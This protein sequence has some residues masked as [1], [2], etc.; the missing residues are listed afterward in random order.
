MYKTTVPI[1]VKTLA[2]YGAEEYLKNLEEMKADRVLLAIESYDVYEKDRSEVLGILK[3]YIPVFRN[4]GFEVG[5]W[6]WAFMFNG[7]KKYTHITSP[8]GA[9]SRGE[10]CPSDEDFRKFAAKCV[11]EI[12]AC[13]PDLILYDDDFR[14]GFLDCGLG[15]ACK[16]HRKYMSEILGEDVSEVELGKKVFGG[17]KN[18]YRSAFLRA[19][20]HFFKV[21]SK[22]MRAA[23][24]SV[25]PSIRIGVCACM[26]VWD[27]C[28]ISPDE[29]S[30]ILAGNTKPFLRLIGA[31]Y[32]S[33]HEGW[34]NK[35]Q[36]V[37]EL[38]R[39]EASWCKSG[40]EIAGEGDC[41]P[42]PRL[43]CSAARL[44]GFDMMLRASGV[45]DGI[46]KYVFDY[47][48][49][50]SYEDGYFRDHM[51]NMGVYELIDRHFEN[52][53][54]TG[55]R[56]YEY[57]NKFED[58]TVP[59]YLDGKDGV[60]DKFFSPAARMLAADGIPAVYEG[61]E[62]FGV[63][64]GENATYLTSEDLARGLILDAVAADI[65]EKRGIDVGLK[66]VGENL[67]A[68]EEHFVKYG[69]YVSVNTNGCKD[70]AVKDGAAVESEFIVGDGRKIA[71]YRYEN[72][73]GNRFLVLAADGFKASRHYIN[74]YAR[75]KQ[76]S[77]AS[78]WFCGKKL[79]AYLGGSPD[80]YLI[81][82]RG[83]NSLSVMIGNFFDDKISPATVELGG[84]YK[85]VEFINC[86]GRLECDK[87]IIESVPPFSCAGFEVFL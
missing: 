69:E 13:Y 36:D 87:V 27:Y 21:F 38:E 11:A 42:R 54:A 43:A 46:M 67:Y 22:E 68:G 77:E 86:K 4:A 82:K 6:L 35:L 47:S 39:M 24:D 84:V 64:F 59:A 9:V 72:A 70:I 30:L 62:Y 31:P 75:S 85:K 74:Q 2:R 80:T 25:D 71:S 40:I 14:Y 3:K 8:N 61:G 73:D 65:L 12:A 26:D 29:I 20:G 28:G 81:C 58:M 57:K 10:V 18:K 41:Y 66:T 78:E 51:A 23:V 52:K 33:V 45:T 15:C 55:A 56:V 48:S 34:S 5:V 63:A 50:P 17:G 19:N 32:W 1:V 79:P 7:D 44:E 76:I 53:T 16:N 49:S 83:E 37:I 60:Q